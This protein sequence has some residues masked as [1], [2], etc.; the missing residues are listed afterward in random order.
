MMMLPARTFSPPNFFTPWYFG[1]LSRPFREEP[2]PFLCAIGFLSAESDVA[3]LHFRE[4]LPVP[5]LARVVFPALVL[6]HDDLVALAVSDD[7]ARDARATER[8]HAGANVLA[9]A[10]EENVV[11]LDAG[12]LIADERG[13][14]VGSSR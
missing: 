13:N 9:V 12:A 1:L 8:R 2:T 3:D 14:L 6:E 10:A 5:L 4:A 7:L 11:E